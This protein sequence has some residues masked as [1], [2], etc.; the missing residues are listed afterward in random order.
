MDQSLVPHDA[1]AASP[2]AAPSAGTP[3]WESDLADLETVPIT[4]VE[5]L[6][7]LRPA[8]RVLEEVL[9]SRDRLWGDGEPGQG[10]LGEP[11]QHS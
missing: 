6:T 10:A 11:R 2:E 1:E 8:T 3:V 5:S 7:P 9:R 4:A